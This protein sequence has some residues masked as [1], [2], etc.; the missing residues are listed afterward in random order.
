M[1][2][3]DKAERALEMRSETADRL[4]LRELVDAYARCAD[5]RNLDGLLA[6]FTSD[7]RFAIYLDG[8]GTDPSQ[9]VE[10]RDALAPAFTDLNR[11]E[12]TTHFNGQSTV[13]VKDER[14]T[15]ETYCLGHLVSTTD[16]VRQI[17]VVSVRYLDTF[18]KVEGRWLFAERAAVVDW[19]DTRVLG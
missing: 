1:K 7:A 19:T 17:T 18:A 12:V 15:G 2:L 9:V 14:A 10:G 3:G 5:R 6:L 13:R 4:A 16:G 11:Y 8:Q